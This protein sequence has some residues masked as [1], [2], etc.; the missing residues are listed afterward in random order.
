MMDLLWLLHSIV[1]VRLFPSLIVL[2]LQVNCETKHAHMSILTFF[3]FFFFCWRCKVLLTKKI[4]VS[5][6]DIWFTLKC[7]DEHHPRLCKTFVFF[8]FN[9]YKRSHHF[10]G[11]NISVSCLTGYNDLKKKLCLLLAWGHLW[12][13][14][15]PQKQIIYSFILPWVT[16]LK[17]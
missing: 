16:I 6:K 3:F 14:K 5:L 17:P 8:F 7:A 11:G 2:A 13:F 10:Y 9:P 15:Q 4:T 12:Y 1:Q